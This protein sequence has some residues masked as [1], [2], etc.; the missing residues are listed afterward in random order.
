M[1]HHHEDLV[2]PMFPFASFTMNACDVVAKPHCDCLNFGSGLCCIVP[3]GTFDPYQDARIGLAEAGVEVE[4]G[5][6]I[7]TFIPSAI[8]T[9]YNTPLLTKGARGV[10]VLWT[11]G[12]IFQYF[13]LGGR[14]VSDLSSYE[15]SLYDSEL[16]AH[17]L[18]SI[19]R[20][21]LHSTKSSPSS[22]YPPV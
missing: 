2:P 15:K 8:V 22:G 16:Q 17:I 21:P 10:V 5:P 18:E 20:F 19:S 3:F 12:S 14:A 6:G 11:N 9:H 7:P 13:A 4:S 1:L